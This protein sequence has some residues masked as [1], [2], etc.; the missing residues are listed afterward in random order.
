MCYS[1]EKG[2]PVHVIY[3][4]E[5]DIPKGDFYGLL[6]YHA[7]DITVWKDLRRIFA[8]IGP[9]DFVFANA[10]V[11]ETSN[12]F[13]DVLDG[14]GQLAEPDWKRVVDV[15]L[16]QC[17]QYSETGMEHDRAHETVG[18]IVITTSAVAYAPSNAC[19]CTQQAERRCWG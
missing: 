12:Y 6:H 11:T 13:S 18:S 15:K 4:E 1:P 8:K 3:L 2:A 10:G 16:V 7:C 17:T 19:P 14:D 9:V 5:F